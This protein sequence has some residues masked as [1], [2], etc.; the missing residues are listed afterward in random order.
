MDTQAPLNAAS[1]RRVQARGL[2]FRVFDQGSGSPLL[3]LH[4][5]PDDLHIWSAV[6]PPLL[7]AGYR[8]I[9]FDQRGCG[10][11]SMPAATAQYRIRQI[12]DDIPALLAALGV[13]QPVNVIGHDWGAAIAW[14]FALYHPQQVQALVAVSVGH[15]RCYGRA[16]LQQK[17]VKGLYTLWFQLRGLAEWYLLRGGGLARWLGNEPDRARIVERMARP[18]RLTAGLNWYRANLLD[19]VLGHWPRCSRPALGIWSSGDKFLTEAQMRDS[20]TQMD[21]AWAYQRI[22]GCGHWIP[23]EQ[24]ERLAALALDWF[25]QHPV[26]GTGDGGAANRD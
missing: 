9:A 22:E 7:H 14:A 18:G 23:R 11:T 25:S 15:P 8:V 1:L 4:G 21:A 10:E 6:I 20:A 26:T 19:V 16:G 3:L 5:F 13:N 12:V 2:D 24:P 17:L